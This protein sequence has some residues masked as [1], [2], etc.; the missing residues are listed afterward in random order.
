MVASLLNKLANYTN[1]PQGSREHEEADNPVT[2]FGVFFLLVL[3]MNVLAL[4]TLNLHPIFGAFR[5]SFIFVLS[6]LY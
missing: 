5:H 6:F 2:V 1:L 3:G 4:T